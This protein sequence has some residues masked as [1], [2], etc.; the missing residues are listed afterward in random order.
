[1]LARFTT[2]ARD[3][4]DVLFSWAVAVTTATSAIGER[5]SPRLVDDAFTIDDMT[6]LLWFGVVVSGWWMYQGVLLSPQLPDAV[7]SSRAARLQSSPELY[8]L[9]A[10]L[11][12]TATVLTN[13]PH[14]VWWLTRRE[15]TLF[16]FTRPRAGNSHYPLSAHDTLASAC[17]GPTYL[18]WFERLGNAGRGP[19]ERRPDLT[20]IV[21]PT[22]AQEVPGGALYRLTARDPQSCPR[23]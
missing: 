3:D 19:G 9:I 14:D 11:P 6:R 5:T 21:R 15:P 1:M 12:A 17:R 20:A 7:A 23:S 13:N 4:A 22:V 2:I 10:D 16:A 8:Q 18:A